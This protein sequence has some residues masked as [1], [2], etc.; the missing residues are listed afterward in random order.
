MK[1]NDSLM[2]D[3]IFEINHELLVD[4][5]ASVDKTT[6][7]KFIS[8]MTDRTA[9]IIKEELQFVDTQTNEEKENAI[10]DSLK[11]IKTILGYI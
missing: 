1:L 6:K 11:I 5:L 10:N 7:N 4:F 3:I 8:N 2:K 9:A